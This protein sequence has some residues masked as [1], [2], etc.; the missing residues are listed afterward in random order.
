MDVPF[1]VAYAQ[2]SQ[3]GSYANSGEMNKR[4]IAAQNYLKSEEYDKGFKLALQ[5][6]D[7]DEGKYA[8]VICYVNEFGTKSSHST[9]AKLLQELFETRHQN[10]MTF[11]VWWLQKKGDLEEAY[12]VTNNVIDSFPFKEMF[13]IAIEIAKKLD[14]KNNP[15]DKLAEITM[16]SLAA[17]MPLSDANSLLSKLP[18]CHL[19]KD[20]KSYEIRDY[21]NSLP[22]EGDLVFPKMWLYDWASELGDLP[23]S[24]L[25]M[26]LYTVNIKNLSNAKIDVK[27]LKSMYTLP[28][29]NLLDGDFQKYFMIKAHCAYCHDFDDQIANFFGLP[30]PDFPDCEPNL[31]LYFHLSKYPNRII[32][33]LVSDG[34]NPKGTPFNML[35]FAICLEHGFGIE[36]D[37]STAISF[38]IHLSDNYKYQE[39]TLY[40]GYLAENGILSEHGSIKKAMHYY[41]ACP[42]S[43][44]AN[45]K[46][47][48]LSPWVDI[49]V[50]KKKEILFQRFTEILCIA[51][52]LG[53]QMGKGNVE[54]IYIAAKWL[55][56]GN[57]FTIQDK[58]YAVEL[59]LSTSNYKNYPFLISLLGV[60]AYEETPKA[61]ENKFT[62]KDGKEMI[63]TAKESSKNSDPFY[64]DIIS[65]AILLSLYENKIDDV[66][67]LRKLIGSHDT[68][69]TLPPTKYIKHSKDIKGYWP[70]N[71]FNPTGNEIDVYFYALMKPTAD[72]HRFDEC[73]AAN[74]P[75]VITSKLF[76]HES[77]AKKID[78]ELNKMLSNHKNKHAIFEA[79]TLIQLCKEKKF[80][81]AYSILAKA[82]FYGTLNGDIIPYIFSSGM[83]KK[84]EKHD[85][86]FNYR[87]N[88]YILKKVDPSV[89]KNDEDRPSFLGSITFECVPYRDYVKS[90][91]YYQESKKSLTSKRGIAFILMNRKVPASPNEIVDAAKSANMSLGSNS[92]D[93]E[94][95]SIAKK[96]EFFGYGNISPF[97]M[98]YFLRSES[99]SLED[100]AKL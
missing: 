48:E 1:R 93:K 28:L 23:S 94:M 15:Y 57:N 14:N 37:P 39:S 82:H 40:L 13:T 75:E 24:Y 80:H 72:S 58:N 29:L 21:A 61:R 45:E 62:K 36:K 27:K 5:A 2:Q 10:A 47:R 6:K 73:I 49:D 33:S 88:P 79:Y 100:Y 46:V 38:Y 97:L 9:A 4:G 89:C 42:D 98:R 86:G 81:K 17:K 43:Y 19:T 16:K 74:I 91:G 63:R 53:D 34:A 41:K 54:A 83:L 90:Y 77:D 52:E 32:I 44:Y 64:F 95:V 7:A 56:F 59:I 8:L 68:E 25:W 26:K 85:H 69:K 35:C 20:S 76:D 99:G 30:T 96:H 55:Y 65:N 60:A 3:L 92:Y 84:I 71:N 70:P 87:I 31:P 11:W 50:I 22:N 12:Q 78:K 66:D 18:F 67:K 51:R